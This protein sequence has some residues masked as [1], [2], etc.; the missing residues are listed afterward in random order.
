MTI[1]IKTILCATAVLATPLLGIT[2]LSQ[3]DASPGSVEYH[4]L[5]CHIF[6]NSPGGYGYVQLFEPSTRAGRSNDDPSESSSSEES[7]GEDGYVFIETH[8]VGSSQQDGITAF[9]KRAVAACKQLAQEVCATYYNTGRHALTVTPSKFTYDP[10]SKQDG[11]R[12]TQS[13]A[14][15][16]VHNV[17]LKDIGNTKR[18][19]D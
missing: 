14:G 18:A 12:F 3:A 19:I 17:P 11:I 5:N 16:A 13:C 7:S 10:Y 2:S 9:T 4:D 6:D 15:K 8:I 1:R